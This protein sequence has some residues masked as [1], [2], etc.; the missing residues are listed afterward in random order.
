[1]TILN[2]ILKH[3]CYLFASPNHKLSPYISIFKHCCSGMVTTKSEEI[4]GIA[5]NPF[6]NLLNDYCCAYGFK[7]GTV[8]TC[9]WTSRE[10]HVFICSCSVARSALTGPK[11][12]LRLLTWGML[13]WVR[14]AYALAIH[15]VC[16]TPLQHKTVRRR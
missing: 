12:R 13:G 9:V 16:L 11:S 5:R 2:K 14:F 8:C 4:W 6:I 7:N 3:A 15:F 10:H 1:M